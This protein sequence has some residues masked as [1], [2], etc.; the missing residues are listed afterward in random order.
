MT[1]GISAVY[2]AQTN[3]AQLLANMD[4][5]TSM[6]RNASADGIC[7]PHEA[8]EWMENAMELAK[9][10]GEA[11]MESSSINA[12]NIMTV[13]ASKGLRVPNRRS[14]GT[15]EIAR[16]SASSILFDDDIGLGLSVPGGN[17]KRQRTPRSR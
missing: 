16:S 9:L 4:K 2:A 5:L 7:M 3:S 13:H 1:S 14:P 6:L 11:P 12:V 15:R 10:E 8:V 17:Y